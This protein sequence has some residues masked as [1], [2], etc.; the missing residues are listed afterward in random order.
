[1]CS[2]LLCRYQNWTG[3]SCS[4]RIRRR[5]L[6]RC[7]WRLRSTSILASSLLHLL[8]WSALLWN[9]SVPRAADVIACTPGALGIALSL[10]HSWMLRGCCPPQPRRR[11]HLHCSWRMLM[12]RLRLAARPARPAWTR[13]SWET[14]WRTW[15]RTAR[16]A[17]HFRAWSR[18]ARHVLIFRLALSSTAR[19]PHRRSRARKAWRRPETRRRTVTA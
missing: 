16:Y 4:W 19:R 18:M 3:P 17:L 6:Q 12:L 7:L 14:S 1:M 10:D 11:E 8:A 2:Q 15:S 5:L 9:G 13:R